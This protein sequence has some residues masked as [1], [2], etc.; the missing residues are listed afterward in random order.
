MKYRARLGVFAVCALA[1]AAAAQEAPPEIA[2]PI[3]YSYNYDS[4]LSPNGKRMVFLKVLEGKEQMFV[5]DSDGRNERQLTRNAIDH[6]DPAWSPDGR[7]I[8]YVHIDGGKKALHVMDVDGSD[9]RRV[10]PPSQSPIHPA[11]MPDSR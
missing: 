4:S 3:T 5:A 2:V 10:T 1:G 8:A 6:E 11:W 7:Y 9:D